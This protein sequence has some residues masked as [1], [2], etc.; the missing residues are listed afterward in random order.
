M[1]VAMISHYYTSTESSLERRGGGETNGNCKG[2]MK[3]AVLIM[4]EGDM[5]MSGNRETGREK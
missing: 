2:T 1:T 5:K 4:V 3:Q